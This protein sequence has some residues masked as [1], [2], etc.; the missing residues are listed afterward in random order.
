MTN[1]CRESKSSWT[2]TR[3]SAGR[4][5]ARSR[6]GLERAV[7][8]HPE[9]VQADEQEDQHQGAGED[10]EA[11]FLVTGMLGLGDALVVFALVFEGGFLET[12]KADQAPVV[13]LER[14]DR[15][16]LAAI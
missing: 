13:L 3:S 16:H 4:R 2:N 15:L 9:L 12:R 1:S 7:L 14:I 8:E 5:R 6:D 11:H 10:I